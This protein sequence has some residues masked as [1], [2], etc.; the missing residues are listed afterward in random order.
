MLDVLSTD[1]CVDQ[2]KSIA[3]TFLNEDYEL[4][5]ELSQKLKDETFSWLETIDKN[6][7]YDFENE[8]E[9]KSYISTTVK[10]I[11]EELE[12]EKRES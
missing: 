7:F 3:R 4:R 10:P 11:L 8:V 6:Q 9:A 1:I 2:F 5:N 12:E